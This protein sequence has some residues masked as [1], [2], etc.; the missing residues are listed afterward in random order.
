MVGRWALGPEEQ[1]G[2]VK[3][4]KYLA[5]TLHGR[6]SRAWLARGVRQGS[7]GLKGRKLHLGCRE[8][9]WVEGT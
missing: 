7:R 8:E 9:D 6:A 1:R 4:L 5:L 3:L 2:V